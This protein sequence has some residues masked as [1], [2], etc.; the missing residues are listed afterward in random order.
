MKHA[1][2]FSVG[3][4]IFVA[5]VALP[6][7]SFALSI[8]DDNYV[9]IEPSSGPVVPGEWN[10]SIAAGKAYAD[11]NNVPML[12][13]YGTKYCTHCHA[14]QSAC[15]TDDFKAW[16][17]EKK[18]VMVFGMDNETKKF[19]KPDDS[20]SLPFVAIYWQKPDDAS[21]YVRFTGMLGDMPSEE[22]NTIAAQLINS[23]NMY[24]G[25]YPEVDASGRL[26]FT[27]TYP[28][29]RLEAEAG[30]TLY[31]D[32]PLER[33][34]LAAG[35]VG[36]NVFSVVYKGA[37]LVEETIV[38][39]AESIS[40]SRRVDMPA[41]AVAGDEI[42]IA[43]QSIEGEDCGTTKIFVVD[44]VENST[45]NPVFVGEKT[46]DELDY[47]EWTMDLDVAMAKYRKELDSHLVAIASGSLWCPDCVMADAH[48]LETAEFKRWAVD[49]KVILVDLDVPNFG[50]R[51]AS[52]ACLLTRTVVKQS[53]GYVSGRDTLATNELERYQSG[54][55]YL[56]RHMIS[57]DDAKRVLE[58]NRSLIGRN[59]LDG[60]WNN[61]DRANQ[62]RTGV[63]SFF[64]LRRDGSLAGTFETFSSI[65]PSE[66]NAAYL[67]RFSELIA[68]A[69]TD[70]DELANRAWQS[71]KDGFAGAGESS[72]ATLAPLDLI[73]VYKLAPTT[74]AASEQTVTVRGSDASAVV[75]VSL[76]AVVDGQRQTLAT[77][78]GR[79]AEGVTAIGV[80]A[81]SG[82]YYVAV[83]GEASG[84]LAADSEAMG[85]T[86]AYTLGG[87]RRKIANPFTNEWTAKDASATLPLYADG[88]DRLA[89]TLA[90]TLKKGGKIKAK[91]SDGKR[92]VVSFSG[93]WNADISIDGT[94]T[95][96]LDKKGYTLKLS[97]SGEGVVKAAVAN[98]ATTVT[99]G[100]CAIADEY[101]AFVGN[102][103]AFLPISNSSD[104]T[105]DAYMTLSMGEGKS[106]VSKGKIKFA[107]FLPDGK[108]LSGTTGISGYD[109]N[110]GLVPIIKSSGA[111]S[112]SAAVLVRRHA[113]EA[114]TRRAVIAMPGVKA[115]LLSGGVAAQC[116]IYGSIIGKN[117]S[118]VELAN[119]T[120][121]AF[122]PDDSGI[123]QDSE[124]GV[125]T[126]IVYKGGMLNMLPGDIVPAERPK[127]FSFKLD[128]KTGVFKGKTSLS[129]TG[130]SKVVAKFGG[131]ILPSWYSDC[132]CQEDDDVVVPME[133]L[134]F[135]AGYGIFTDKTNGSRAKR[136]FSV[137]LGMDPSIE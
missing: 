43:L 33:D 81:S 52:S 62:Y 45:K 128:S 1:V 5:A 97:M 96:A 7:P 88:G 134:P 28:R 46:A 19:C 71:T 56:S 44:E 6:L 65:G 60:G 109:A 119:A 112:F 125:L 38:W 21:V 18:I 75:T 54:T 3:F 86:V 105:G 35:H 129:F 63:P 89:G 85:A 23:C 135:G 47:G 101:G 102:Y 41:G 121:V 2:W 136:S 117:E 108:R 99:S 107:V 91:F 15:N 42:G 69:D 17:A 92:V 66:Y 59:T 53:D 27:A 93:K 34:A 61:P 9:P 73:D 77:A 29:A 51:E 103:T 111:N 32:V 74:D 84:A 11:A 115:E 68:L 24:L 25:D 104:A 126:G 90:L 50:P 20:V 16:A 100:S 10:S 64:S 36:T 133:F 40:M 49:N 26:A 72:G 8:G 13:I 4:A 37:K 30:K 95:A 98:G 82:D 83:E 130:K 70:D 58:R 79:L 76:F 106:A 80:I 116:G 22:G 114:M 48:V 113:G 137:E 57:D 127:G 55:C 31:V 131:V 12:A 123:G 124:Y 120:S 14:I 110:F 94:A 122:V 87:S 118:L 132:E 67:S 39:S 78:S